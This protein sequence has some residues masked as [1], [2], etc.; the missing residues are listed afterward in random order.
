MK[1]MRIAL[2][3][4]GAIG[5][6]VLQRAEGIT[7]IHIAF[8]IVRH[9]KLSSVQQQ[10]STLHLRN[11]PVVISDLTDA[12]NDLDAVLECAGHQA[13]S[14]HIKP[15]LEHGIRCAVVSVGALSD[16]TLHE[17]LIAAARQGNTQVHLLSGAM[18]GIDA[19]AAARHSGLDELTYTGRKP[20][21]GWKGSPAEHTVALDSLTEPTVFF[22]GSAREAAAK[23]PKNANVAATLALAG[24][25]L[26]AA[27]VRLI[28]DPTVK[29]NIHEVY[30]RGGFGEMSL[31]MRGKPLPNNP[32]TS[33]LTVMSALRFLSNCVNS[34]VM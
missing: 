34:T 30:V 21:S 13:L 29:D 9:A 7:G 33:T 4:Y 14:E 22:S 3:G 20:P 10:I 12:Y 28:A 25:G 27:Q 26:D 18:G 15:A 5:Q 23:F 32:K 16:S 1:S 6:E 24:N 11:A 19:I 8:C 2:V 17:D 31:T